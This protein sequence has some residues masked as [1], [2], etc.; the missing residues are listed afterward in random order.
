MKARKERG[1]AAAELALLLPVLLLIL[2]GCIDLGR[3]FASWVTLT[4]AA[5]EG[6]RYGSMHPADTPG[7]TAAAQAEVTAGGMSGVTIGIVR[8]GTAAG[9]SVT[10]SASGSV[11]L[12]TPFLGDTAVPMRAQATMVTMNDAPTGG[13]S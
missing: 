1:Q 9:S 2:L 10:V 3:M 12:T 11:S 4:N 6:A 13:G 8:S 7:I 5:R